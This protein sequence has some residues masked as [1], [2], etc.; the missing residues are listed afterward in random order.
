M[1]QVGAAQ[2]TP[3]EEAG[4]VA[5]SGSVVCVRLPPEVLPPTFF[6]SL[7]CQD[8]GQLPHLCSGS[9]RQLSEERSCVEQALD[10]L[11]SGPNDV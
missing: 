2:S 9:S 3:R 8:A 11:V 5:K 4:L 7:L 10:L 6:C 1:A